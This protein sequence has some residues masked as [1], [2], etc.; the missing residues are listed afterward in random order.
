M[1][2][3]RIH[4]DLHLEFAGWEP[5]PVSADVVV[6]AGD[7]HVGVA[8][9]RWMRRH[10]PDTPVVYVPGNHEYFHG[11]MH[12]VLDALR[13]EAAA[14]GIHV[15]D[16][17]EVVLAGARFLGATLW[18]DF[19]IYG[20][21][22][23]QVAQT[24]ASA[25]RLM[26]DYRVIRFGPQG[27]FK[28]EHALKLHR[29]HVRWLERKLVQPF[30][31]PTVVVTHHLPH[32]LSIHPKFEDDPLNPGFASDL[33]YLVRSPVQLW[34]HGHTHESLDYVTDGTR[35]VCNPRGYIPM[36][37]NLDFDPGLVVEVP[38]TTWSPV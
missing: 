30:A 4:S 13:A 38:A 35:V 9:L 20:T 34:A 23:E 17:D 11:R 7:I 25:K 32:R 14:L 31:G 18:T 5:P 27:K 26:H 3:I 1:P 16:M 36:Q 29:E 21:E 2:R 28:P 24:M 37:P 19:A 15:L 22:P 8:G 12:D 10:F 6:L 33:A